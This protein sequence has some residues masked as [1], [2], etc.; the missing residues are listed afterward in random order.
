MSRFEDLPTLAQVE[1]DRKDQ[2]IK[3]GPSRL[4]QRSAGVREQRRRDQQFRIAIWLRDG[5]ECRKCGSKVYR[6]LTRTAT[7]AEV[8]HLAGKIGPLRHDI[9]NGLL[10]CAA[11]HELL[12]GR[13]AERWRVV[14]TQFFAGVDH[15]LIDATYAVTFERIV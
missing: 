1:A 10:C 5:G 4:Q 15:A 12:T 9:R 3:K 8:H 7:R 14:G 13:V 11:C 6:A 2:P